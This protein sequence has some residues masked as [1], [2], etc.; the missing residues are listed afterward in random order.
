MTSAAVP[1]LPGPAPGVADDAAPPTAT[2]TLARICVAVLAAQAAALTFYLWPQWRHDP[3]LSHGFFMPLAFL[4]LW[5]E[6]G[7]HGPARHPRAG[8]WSL[9]ATAALAAIAFAA[10]AAAGLFAVSLGWSH[11]LVSF[12]LTGASVAALLAGL[13]A[14]S[15]EPLRMVSLNWTS[16]AAATMWLLA[17]PMP[18]G[19]YSTVTLKLQ[20]GVTGAV[21]VAL[22]LLGVAARQ[23][24]HLIELANTTVGVEEACSGIRS[25]LSCVFVGFFLSAFLLRRPWSRVWLLVLAPV[26]AVAMNF[27][28]SLTLTLLV[29]AG[30]DINGFWHDATGYAILVVTAVLLVGA[31]HLAEPAGARPR[32]AAPSLKPAPS[33]R[34]AL[35]LS[36]VVLAVALVSGGVLTSFFV[37]HTR[38]AHHIGPPPDLAAL[39]P[40]RSAGWTV[41]TA[42][43]L[44]RF[45]GILETDNLVQ[46]TYLKGPESDPT[47]ITVYL[48]YWAPGQT[49]VSNVA[50]HTP[51]ACWPGAGWQPVPAAATRLTPVVGGRTLPPAECR[52]FTNH[53]F[54]QYVW[55][56]HLYD[57]RA[58]TQRDP[59]SPRELLALAWR[60][61]F[62]KDGDQLFV[63]V[64]SN[65]PWETVASEPLL[66]EI[67]AHLRPLG[68]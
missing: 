41:E 6:S 35:L 66:T 12:T 11:S 58:I 1:D 15:P 28:R 43:D 7:R 18:P 30:V 3:D 23:Q 2:R 46:R 53:G 52:L 68:F 48:A 25:L 62:R 21:L 32:E 55:F 13:F 4:V 59:R 36:Q 27:V 54:P 65:R 61:G 5:W 63:R 38:P 60:Y 10:L 22:H 17:A 40:A 45:A 56:W 24:G 29:N 19:T 44:N 47:Q 20:T 14:L 50:V 26:L 42:G 37:L 16:F 57:G 49:T 34:R 51:D 31:A 67:F 39:L 64:S 33:S 8:A 9:L